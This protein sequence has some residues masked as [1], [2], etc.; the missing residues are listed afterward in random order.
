[1]EPA[2]TPDVRRRW[3]VFLVALAGSVVL[4]VG[5]GLGLGH[6][7]AGAQP[8]P[9]LRTVPAAMLTQSG[10]TLTAAGQPPYCG[11]ASGAAER[12][13]IPTSLAGCA[14]SAQQAKGAL[15]PAFQG[16]VTEMALARVSG[17]YASHLGQ[18]RL[19]WLVVV[20]SSLLVLPTT[21]CT[22]PVVTD[23]GCV[24]RRLG[25]TSAQAIV[26]VDGSTGQVLTTLP[27]P[28]GPAPPALRLPGQAPHE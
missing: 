14:I 18:D 23:P 6:L 7:G 10:I 2:G 11:L 17:P 12:R 3:G 27:V 13:W 16:G 5:V 8:A 4:A 15:L 19:V 28:V 1:M 22:S 25:H 21:D 26:F 24:A 9:R 20:R